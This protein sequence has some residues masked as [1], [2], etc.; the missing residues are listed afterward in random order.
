MP[1]ETLV[2]LLESFKVLCPDNVEIH[3]SLYDVFK[4]Q[5]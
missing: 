4:N 2:K 3:S 5:L 1:R